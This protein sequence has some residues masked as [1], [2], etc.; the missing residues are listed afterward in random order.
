M[1]AIIN[2]QQSSQSFR[3]FLLLSSTSFLLDFSERVRR[4][5]VG[6]GGAR[7]YFGVDFG[8]IGGVEASFGDLVDG[9]EHF[10]LFV[11]DGGLVVAHR[12]VCGFD[13]WA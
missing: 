12:L 9:F 5:T 11:E 10:T 3:L 1:L 7:V 4:L 2:I 6:S 8:V 13:E